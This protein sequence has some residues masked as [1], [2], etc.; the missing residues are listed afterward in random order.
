MKFEIK[1][2]DLIRSP[3]TGM[4]K[5]HW[6]DACHFLME[7]IFLNISSMDDPIQA[8]RAEFKVS[9]PNESSSA[10]KYDS[11]RFEGLARSFLIAAPLLHNEPE[12]EAG[13]LSLREYYRRAIL[14]GVTPGSGRYLRNLRE[15]EDM[16]REG[17]RTFQH[18]CECASLVI[19][20]DQCRAVIWETYSQGEKDR[21]A[22]YLSEFGHSRTESHNWR[23]FNMLIL[24]FLY[25]EGYEIDE[26]IMREHGQSILSYY[27]GNGWYRDGHRFDYYTPWAFQ[28]YGPIW[29]VWYGYEKEPY[30]AEKI[31]QYANELVRCFPSMFD[32]D[33]HVTMWGRSSLY[34]NAAT[35]PFAADFLLREPA[36]EPGLARR[37]NSGALLQ[38]LCRED[39]F[40]NGVPGLGFYGPFLPAVQGYSCAESPFWIA[41]PFV[42]LCLPDTHPFWTAT[43][44]NGDWETLGKTE[45]TSIVMDGPGI[46]ADH[47]GG[48]GA[49]EFRTAKGL[50]APGDEY[51][52]YYVRLA[53]HSH[54]P[55]EDFD[56]RGAEAMQYSLT[57][58]KEET[59]RVP[60]I[61]LYGGVRDGV[62]YRKEYFDFCHSFQGGASLELGDFSVANGMIRVDRMRIPDSPFTL[63]MGAY[64]MPAHAKGQPMEPVCREENNAQAM[65]LN[66]GKR[67]LAL[68]IYHGFE[69]LEV[70]R[71]SGVSAFGGESMLIYGVCRRERYY[72]CGPGV[73]VSAVLTKEGDAPWSDEELFPIRELRFGADGSLGGYGTVILEMKDG[74]TV[75]VDY[76]GLEGRLM[77]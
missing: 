2:P 70:K 4:T 41:N 25:R 46:V 63:T 42:A 59:G 44:H 50:F 13:G 66:N 29:N 68:V 36:A 15:L 52:R 35:A 34:R 64:G 12:A 19:G 37:I 16:A 72:E 49:A 10:A 6:L 32:R 30:I 51:I 9:Y 73:L 55:W 57:Y 69:R 33:G 43:E 22:K 61:M 62:L 48:A 60:N 53:F 67:Q 5:R 8:V 76:E 71:R 26:E 54:F 77:I 58:G 21:I 14:D 39:V 74:R 65:I 40:V 47:Q 7:G 1:S 27:A 3:Y 24:A 23:L 28:V 11:Q 31:E 20:L 45:V 38:F 18:T 56:Y 17:E 75:T